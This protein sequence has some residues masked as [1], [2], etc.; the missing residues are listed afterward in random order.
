MS[1]KK[2]KDRAY[3][4]A[5]QKAADARKAMSDMYKAFK[6]NLSALRKNLD[7][8]SKKLENMEDPQTARDALTGFAVQ[9]TDNL[10]SPIANQIIQAAEDAADDITNRAS[11]RVQSQRFSQQLTEILKDAEQQDSASAAAR[12]SSTKK[13]SASMLDND[14]ED[15]DDGKELSGQRRPPPPPTP[16]ELLAKADGRVVSSKVPP[17]PK[18][19]EP[20]RPEPTI[21]KGPVVPP[22]PVGYS[23]SVKKPLPTISE[24][25]QVTGG[26]TAK[27]IEA[28]KNMLAGLSGAKLKKAAGNTGA[29]AQSP[30]NK[31]ET[32]I[33]GALKKRLEGIRRANSQGS[34][35]SKGSK[36]S[37][38]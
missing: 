31:R 28:Q 27:Q 32:S 21:I 29:T 17:I 30:K 24:T 15:S 18:R 22:K 37:W 25:K 35:S 33:G 1:G 12:Q 38:D 14:D 8:F 16:D 19:P 36:N 3:E 13:S 9:A 11:I 26:P 5:A 2:G 20:K 10:P 4:Y 23:T 6:R 7:I 34:D